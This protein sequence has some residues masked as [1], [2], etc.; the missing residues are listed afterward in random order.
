MTRKEVK[1]ILPI[2]QAYAEGKTIKFLKGDKWYN[3]YDNDFYEPAY[4]YRIK[5]EEKYRPFKTK[6]ECWTEMHKHPDFGWLLKSGV[7]LHILSLYKDALY[8]QEEDDAIYFDNAFNELT[9]TY[10]TPFGI[11]EE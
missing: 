7:Y 3:V 4:K 1:E 2:M 9:F 6:E 8:I 10:G 5:P 11:K